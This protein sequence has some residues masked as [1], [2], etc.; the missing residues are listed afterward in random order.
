MERN[1]IHGKLIYKAD[2][3]ENIY[4]L[5]RTIHNMPDVDPDFCQGDA[6]KPEIQRFFC[7]LYYYI[8]RCKIWD[9][10]VPLDLHL[11]AKM[12][13]KWFSV[14]PVAVEGGAGISLNIDTSLVGQSHIVSQY[15]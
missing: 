6:L 2:V 7:L 10:K 1:Y 14:P 4:L 12:I 11:S 15:S 8:N 13:V 3:S 5:Q 9:S